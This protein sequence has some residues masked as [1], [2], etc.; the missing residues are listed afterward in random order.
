[1]NVLILSNPARG[2]Y[3]FFNALAMEFKKDRHD[4]RFAV[5][6]DYTAN[7]NELG[8]TGL[9]VHV[10]TDFISLQDKREMTQLDGYRGYNLNAALLS[11][12]E[13]SQVQGSLGMWN[14]T[15]ADDIKIHLLSFFEKIVKEHDTDVVIF[16]NVSDMFAYF[17]WFV[18]DKLGVH[19]CGLTSSRLPGRFV[20]TND[21]TEESA[22]I[23][24]TMGEIQL[25]DLDVPAEARMWCQDYIDKIESIVPDYMKFNGLGSATLFSNQDAADKFR[26][27]WG[28]IRFSFSTGNSYKVGNPLRKRIRIA[29]RAIGRRCRIPF[30]RRYYDAP[31]DSE[32]FLLYPLHYHPESSTSVLAASYL[33][34]YEV[35][36]NIAFNLPYG[37]RLYVKD[38]VSA[39]G[40][41]KRSFYEALS[42]LPNVRLIEPFA[43]T[44]ELIKRS[45]AVIA[46]TSTVGYEAL[47]MGKRVFLY[48]RVFYEF[49]PNVVRV[50]DPTGL[51]DLLRKWLGAPL[52]VGREYNLA[53]VEAYYM[54]SL[55]GVLDMVGPG[56]EALAKDVYPDV[57]A[58]LVSRTPRHGFINRSSVADVDQPNGSANPSGTNARTPIERQLP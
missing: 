33:D 55:P 54:C 12:F 4:V 38:H 30:I 34:E 22:P 56:A 42:H 28:A 18:C 19:Y 9:P 27:W 52:P 11:D 37:V 32:N 1:M 44:K 49:H 43:K 58:A 24:A 31:V 15:F 45:M 13:R 8:K 6:C 16:E 21:P 57:L 46:L 10:L 51:F 7:I 29:R 41:P 20:L 14:T 47:L 40:I 2:Y 17:C 3:K 26:V 25:G 35:I 36:R 5:D 50:Q 39:F 48:G 53:F 23:A